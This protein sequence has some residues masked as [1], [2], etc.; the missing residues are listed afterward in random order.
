MNI[1][2]KIFR[3]QP[4]VEKSGQLMDYPVRVEPGMSVLALL[5][6]VHDEQDGTL[7]YRYSC[8]GAI[9]GTCAININGTPRLACKTQVSDLLKENEMIVLEPLPRF[10]VVKD[11]VVD[12]RP[13]WDAVKKTQPWLVRTVDLPDEKMFY[14]QDLDKSHL[15]QLQ[16]AADCIKCG[17]CYADCPKVAEMPAFIGPAISIQL[18][19]QLFDP[20]DKATEERLTLGAAA[21]GVFECDKHAN[22]VKVCPKD[23]R[24]LRAI[25]FA[26]QKVKAAKPP[27]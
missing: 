15:D 26:Q 10:P 7:S 18:Y 6:Q 8:R 23:C 20:R 12:K 5:H 19:K 9:C 11:L 25:T 3:Y 22:C 21:G 1:T 27:V 24:P 13:F 17:C 14:E 16:R 4:S 2:V